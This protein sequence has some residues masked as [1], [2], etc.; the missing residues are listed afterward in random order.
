MRNYVKLCLATVIGN[1]N[2]IISSNVKVFS[3]YITD[4]INLPLK[5]ITFLDHFIV[6]V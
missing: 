3:T 2:I 1:C 5:G 6:E 4:E